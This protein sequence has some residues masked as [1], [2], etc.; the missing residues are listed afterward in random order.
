MKT[1]H[2]ALAALLVSSA[3]LADTCPSLLNHRFK[4]VQGT[5][6]DLCQYA[7]R[8][9]LVVNT[10]S[11]C[12]FTPQFAK[13]QAMYDQYKDKG[14][15]VVGFPS[16]DFRQEL[17]TNKEVGEFC[18]TN[19]NVTFPMIEKTAVKGAGAN[20]L[21]RQLAQR[22]GQEPGWNFHKYLISP[23]G[24][25]VYSFPTSTE[26]DAAEIRAKLKLMLK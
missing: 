7:D 24:R 14:L 10:A 4:S 12:G 18:L 26:P 5:D 6:V 21:F 2:L 20:P 3:A 23:G 19:Y 25:D 11:R 13:L 9:I 15:V 17:A 8:A 16:N 22:T 1:H